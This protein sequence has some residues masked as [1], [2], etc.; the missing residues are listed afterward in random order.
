MGFDALTGD[1]C[2]EP[3]E[4][5]KLTRMRKACLLDE[6]A[7]AV[8]D[9]RPEERL[10]VMMDELLGGIGAKN[11]EPE[12]WLLAKADGVVLGAEGVRD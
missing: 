1:A 9:E 4:C 12:D 7:T 10:L 11:E 8:D 5:S 6:A 2:G 3:R